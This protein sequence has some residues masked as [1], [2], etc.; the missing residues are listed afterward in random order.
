M[1]AIAL[2]NGLG[3]HR[4][5]PTVWATS[6]D[7]ARN[8]TESRGTFPIRRL[9]PGALTPLNARGK[10]TF[11]GSLSNKSS[12]LSCRTKQRILCLRLDIRLRNRRPQRVATSALYS[13]IPNYPSPPR[14]LWQ[15]PDFFAKNRRNRETAPHLVPWRLSTVQTIVL[16][17]NRSCRA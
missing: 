7:R 6:G 15:R 5:R 13:P 11:W 1:G 12:R 8:W 10:F 17:R 3:L 14:H 16:C 4:P 2:L 9:V